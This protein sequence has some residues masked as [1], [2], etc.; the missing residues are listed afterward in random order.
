M[1]ASVHLALVA[2]VRDTYRLTVEAGGQRLITVDVAS[3]DMGSLLAAR[4]IE[5]EV[6]SLQSRDQALSAENCVQCNEPAYNAVDTS[7]GRMHPE[8]ARGAG[9]TVPVGTRLFRGVPITDPSYCPTCNRRPTDSELADCHRR[10][11]W[12]QP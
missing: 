3:Q 9:N 10:D 12:M 8:C 4:P 2:G 1:K 11:C 7:R 6:V 5:G